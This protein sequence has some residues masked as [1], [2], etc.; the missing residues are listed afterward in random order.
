MGACP[1]ISDSVAARIGDLPLAFKEVSG[2][3]FF[4]SSAF[5]A[6]R[7]GSSPSFDFNLVIWDQKSV[8][9]IDFE[10]EGMPSAVL[11]GEDGWDFLRE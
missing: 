9:S 1:G 3:R 10:K 2:F 6:E 4:E 8:S 7:G 11:A 5:V